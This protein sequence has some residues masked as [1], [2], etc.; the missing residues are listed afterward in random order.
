MDDK[1]L[2]VIILT[3]RHGELLKEALLSV[4]QQSYPQIE[5]IIAEDGASDFDKTQIE[6]YINANRKSN[7]VS[8]KM[9]INSENRGTVINL[10]NA[11]K[12]A[13]GEYIKIIA[14]DDTYPDESIFKK[15]VKLLKNSNK[16]LVFGNIIECDAKMNP[17]ITKGFEPCGLTFLLSG[18]KKQLRKYIVK[19]DSSLISTQS[20][21]FKKRFFDENGLYD[22]RLLLIEDLP[23]AMR[24]ISCDSY[25]Y[26][27]L[28]AVNHRGDVGISSSRN[29]FDRKKIKYY[30]DLE[31]YFDE[32]LNPW[33][34]E[35]GRNYLKMR[36]NVCRFR[37]K[38]SLL[39][40]DDK[41]TKIK[42][43]L[44]YSISLVY[45]L[46]SNFKQT[47][48]HLKNLR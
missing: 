47:R 39:K 4:F 38:Y 20:I 16:D 37:I 6:A 13:N 18:N 45:Y 29:T 41:I 32:V 26:Q 21:C 11:I 15:Q 28:D 42:L 31:I 23:M 36:A 44:Q 5:V 1:L 14:G 43:I 25:E 40:T 19:V 17:I 22:E 10:N 9:L 7:I 48:R 34:N 8:L 30:K 2:S 12:E 35:I 33:R 46:I 24:I 3:Y 27:N